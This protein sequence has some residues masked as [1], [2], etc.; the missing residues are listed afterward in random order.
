[1]KKALFTGTF[2]P[3][4]IGH[5]S[6]VRRAL[7]FMDEIVIAVVERNVHKQSLFSNEQRVKMIQDLYADEPRVN[8]LPFHN[9]AVD[10][11]KEQ[12]AQFIIRGVRS[13]SD[14]EYEKEM[15]EMNKRLSGIETILLLTE[16]E[17]ACVSSSTVR[18][19]LSYGKDVSAFLPKGMKLLK[20]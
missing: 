9:L 18:E 4:T 5:D 14:F 10:F 17:L 15:A 7:T 16:P 11:A 20:G 1:M 13:I 12:G 8:V 6:V 2:D 19:L 3:Y